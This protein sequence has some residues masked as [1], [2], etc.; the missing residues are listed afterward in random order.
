MNIQLKSDFL[1]IW[2]KYFPE[3]ELPIIFFHANEPHGV[4][5]AK[6]VTGWRCFIGDLAVVRRGQ[7]MC[8]S[9]ETV[10]CGKRFLG[11]DSTLR[12][13]FDEFLSCGISGQLE[14]ERYK[15]SPELVAVW[16]ESV[17]A[18]ISDQKY[19]V[20]KRWDAIDEA[21][22]PEAVIFFATNDALSGL[23]TWANFDE[24]NAEA[25]AAP[26]G[27]GC[28]SIVQYP[29]LEAKKERPRAILGM[30]DVSARPR[31]NHNILT[32]SIPFVKFEKMIGNAEQTFFI[33]KSWNVVRD[34]INRVSKEE[35]ERQNS[36][37]TT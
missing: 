7:P 31:V 35:A 33:T 23:F 2:S 14:G 25:V 28:A 6:T 3:A 27:A 30:F 16:K 10:G 22:Q 5:L 18:V 12:P 11:L 21:D 32:F 34:R 19:I 20:F 36:Q 8:Y 4:E 29:L 17:P 13:N 1:E 24:P 15:Q 9:K 26:F 37:K